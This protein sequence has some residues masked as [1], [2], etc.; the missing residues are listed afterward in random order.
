VSFNP[1]R[2]LMVI[3]DYQFGL[4]AGKALFNENIV[5]NLE[6]KYSRR[7]K[8]IRYA[9]LNK[10]PYVSV[11]TSDGYL[12]LSINAAKNL[13]ENY[14]E[15][16][17]IIVVYNQFEEIVKKNK[18]VLVKY[19]KEVDKNLKAGSEVIVVNEDRKILGI[20]RVILNGEEILGLKRGSAV[21]LR[22]IAK[23][24]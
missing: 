4:G 11:R 17:N 10:V 15:L 20:G 8:R 23:N 24:V 18:N 3:A 6:I 19:V 14:K 21:K 5:K 2:I 1:I 22:K 13:L 16:K 9:L 7:T 12:T